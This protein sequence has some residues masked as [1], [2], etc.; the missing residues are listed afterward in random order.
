MCKAQINPM[1]FYKG[2][3]FVIGN[4]KLSFSEN[5]KQILQMSKW[6]VLTSSEK[7]TGD[8]FFIKTGKLSGITVFDVDIKN[9][10]NGEDNL[11]IEAELDFN[12]FLDDCIKVNTPSGGFHYLFPYDPRFKTG[13]N[14]FEIKG[15]DIRNDDAIVFSGNRYNIDS[16]GK[17]FGKDVSK[18]TIDLIWSKFEPFVSETVVHAINQ[19]YYE[20]VDL[21]PDEYFNDYEKWVK[22][23]YALKN[24]T[25]IDD[26][27]GLNTIIALIEKR[28]K[29]PNI[30]EIKRIWTLDSSKKRF[31]I[32]SIVNVL[33]KDAESKSK[34]NAWYDKWTAKKEDERKKSLV[35][36][37]KEKLLELC[38][39]TY[40]RERYTGVV[41]E[42]HLSYYYVRKYSEPKDFLNA[43]F[44]N[45]PLFTMQC[46]SSMHQELV[47][48]IK[49]IINIDF[50][51][52]EINNDYIGFNNGIYDLQNA[53]FIKS[54][55]VNENIQVRTLIP[56][57]FS[58]NDT[59]LLD[60]YFRYQFDDETIDFIYFMVGR[61]LTKINDRFDFMLYLFGQGGTGKSLLLN[62]IKYS[63][64]PNQIGILSNSHQE[65]FGLSEFAKKQILCCD[66][67]N[68]LA[69]TLPKADFLSMCTRGSIQCPVKGKDSIEIADWNIPSVI[70]SNYLPNYSDK[71]GEV[72]RR[73]MIL[74][75]ENPI[76][77]SDM[78]TQL[79]YDIKRTEYPA[80]LHKC[81]STYLDLL[82]KYG[83]KD[84]ESFCPQSFIEN[85]DLLREES[86]VSYMFAK[87]RLHYV[88][89]SQLTIKQ[90][91]TLLK[92]YLKEKYDTKHMPK[93]KINSPNI[94]LADS[95][96]VHKNIKVC[97]S[98]FN[99]HIK[100]CC[101]N[102]NRTNRTTKSFIENIGIKY[103]S[104]E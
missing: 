32:G 78:N 34:L 76:D 3:G 68:N 66:D 62:L 51:F 50:P 71:A 63:F 40:K 80:F 99:P 88:E 74:N 72:I 73:L 54:E 47:Y 90:L 30:E 13:A 65:R 20:L 55:D 83:S 69:K 96:Y 26:E 104:F 58:I 92:E 16:V 59:P 12:E 60:K 79:E 70:N 82:K 6:K 9:D 7:I 35:E 89:G 41:Y 43:I 5:K 52:M 45:E 39:D 61:L 2:L 56:T 10:V 67:M 57:D 77:K 31:N 93:E 49:N 85:R 64:N 8:N 103:D 75:F 27:E 102:Y 36:V 42:K 98:C 17:N 25:D 14:C 53:Q 23:L 97:K 11:M 33:K 1:D 15:F 95:R 94:I 46:T 18:K 44:E 87:D 21:L 4:C 48:F 100:G 19:K 37:L 84:V 91:N 38:Q 101:Q 86:N 29:C 22:P 24:A 81:R 28:S